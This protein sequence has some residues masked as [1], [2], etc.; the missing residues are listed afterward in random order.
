MLIIV[1]EEL[2][3]LDFVLQF[4]AQCF[5]DRWMLGH[6]THQQHARALQN[7]FGADGT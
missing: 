6:L 3:H 1:L 5:G 4:P 2:E 7:R